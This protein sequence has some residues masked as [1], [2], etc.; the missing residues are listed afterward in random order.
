MSQD[1]VK[2]LRSWQDIARLTAKE[3]DP[4]KAL[5]LAQELIRA[6][7]EESRK[8]MDNVSAAE[9]SSEKGAR[10]TLTK[11]V[12]AN[13]RYLKKLHARMQRNRAARVLEK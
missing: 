2:P 1:D 10:T 6:L 7:D 5:E 3:K 4:T 9:K 8:R 12:L 13:R 11:Y